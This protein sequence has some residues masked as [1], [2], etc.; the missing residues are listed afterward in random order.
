MKI[1]PTNL[2]LSTSIW[3]LLHKID[4]LL[5]QPLPLPKR[6]D[7]INT[8]L[9]ETLGVDAIWFIT[10]PPLP[11]AACGVMRT[12]LRVA[13]QAT[14]S[15]VDTD[16]LAEEMWPPPNTLL[17]QAIAGQTPFFVEP[18]G[19][20]QT[21]F[22]LGDTFFDTF[23]VV[24]IA[25]VPLI[26]DDAL[27]GAFVVGKR[28][29]LT[30]PLSNEMQNMLAY[31]GKHLA[32]NLQN[33]YLVERSERH[34]DV[35]LTLNQIAQ[36]ITSSLDI[37]DVIQKTMAGINTVLDVEAGSL[38]LLDE[39]TNELYFK[40]TLRGENKQVASYRLKEGEGIAGWV[41]K[42]NKPAMVNDSD[43]DKRFAAKIDQAIGFKTN[44]V[45]CAPLV[46][47]G[48]PTGALEVLNKR[49]GPFDDDDQEL[50]VSMTAALG[51]ALQ[52]ARLYEAAQERAYINE[53]INEITAAINAGY[54]LSDTAKTIFK[55]F[56]RLFTFDHISICSLDNG[57]ENVRQW[58]FG[59][60]GSIEQTKN[61]IPLKQSRLAQT[62]KK[63]RGYI[64]EDIS[65]L[66][67]ANKIY[68]DDQIL[69]LDKVVSKVTVPLIIHNTPYGSLTLGSQQV[70]TYSP[71]DLRLLEQLTPQ[72]A[73]AIDK[74]LLIDAMEQRT[75]E[76]QLLNRLGEMLVSTTEI[77]VI[78]ETTLNML[79]RLLPGDVQGVVIASEEGSYAGVAVPFGFDRVK[80][81]TKHIFNTY[82]ELRN[83]NDVLTELI[84][85]KSVAGN[86]PVADDWEPITV[87]SLPILTSRGAQ[88]IIYMASGKEEDLGDDLLR[89]FSLIVSQI[90][91]A[92][93]NAH[94]FHEIEQERARL[95]AI[96]SSSTDAVL[97]VNRNGRIVLDN[98]AA[99]E[100]IGST[101]SQSGHLLAES[102]S[103]DSLINLFQ[104][105]IQGST[106]TGEILLE[107]GRT[108]FANLSPVSVG[109]SGVIGWVATMQDVSHFKEL[110]ELKNDFV[111]TVSHDLR[112]PLGSILIATNL[113]SQMSK[114]TDD[115][116]E[117]L[118]L[119]EGR[120]KAM[121]ELIDHLLDV[122][123]IEAG[124]DMDM[125]PCNLAAITSD[126][127]IALM[128]Q[129]ADKDIQ[130]NTTIDQD[131]PLVLA[132]QTRLH[133]VLHNLVSNAI[134]YTL[135]K[136]QVT[137]KAYSHENEIRIQVNDT[138]IGIPASDQPHIFEKF[139]R[140]RG[141]HVF[142]IKG[143][144]LGL[145]I[146]KGIIE[147]HNGR[148]LLESVLG[149]GSA[150]TVALP[151][152]E[153]K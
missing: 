120:V 124:I 144:G 137:V 151:I 81:T 69:V 93:E 126:V 68:P 140:V 102:T 129:A 17:D 82:L 91:A 38:L 121:G 123:S 146:V 30:S 32:K 67:T 56:D 11:T 115:Q 45:L 4:N 148:I 132:N 105:A 108:F 23:N 133:Q 100:V 83:D 138:G 90:S 101:E 63:G 49:T 113:I 147:K 110:D 73:I 145:A 127:T 59:D 28:K 25:I 14:I 70:G 19:N 79:P 86:M 136:G 104:E 3:Q 74:A 22:D 55:Q 47:Q 27:L 8:I 85:S 33:S 99:W 39:D 2:M 106:L 24:P 128:S 153:A 139:Y 122:G 35:L 80:R 134:K 44:T 84:S 97:V 46:V 89:I 50:L 98:P 52:N 61:I 95:A 76:L 20:H 87:L 15:V 36:T 5:G 88:G 7:K 107:D 51:I 143:T 111:N 71:K 29:N 10:V 141:D 65:Y 26:A 9:I 117:L 31:L 77:E 125:E 118:D 135:D 48:K 58:I 57:K 114:V 150:F 152:Y 18:N 41:I 37:D 60:F 6:L 112:S 75:T 119:I 54:S 96:L 116:Q 109:E 13:P 94:L 53:V 103:V 149:E 21:G 40:I 42:H 92:V 131:L 16:P 66:K 130:L 43:T 78:V 142:D 12:P 1:Q 62:M 34:N 64:E 72:V